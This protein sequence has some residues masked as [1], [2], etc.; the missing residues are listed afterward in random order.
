MIGR[1]RPATDGGDRG[2]GRYSRFV[3]MMKVALPALALLLTVVVVVWPRLENTASDLFSV[4]F[5]GL[6]G[7]MVES[8]R[9]VNARY[10]GTDSDN[11]PFM[12]TADLAEE[13][14]AGSRVVRL[15]HPKADLTL[16]DGA[17]V[18]MGADTGLYYQERG[19]LELQ[20][21]VDLFHDLG[22]EMHT[23][24]VI[25]NMRQGTAVGK[26]PV[27]AQGPTG[28]LTAEGFTYDRAA[29]RVEF[30]G[31]A[32][33]LMRPEAMTQEETKR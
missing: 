8:Q 11:R 23:P 7:G 22:Y 10:H 28:S 27:T 5:S 16:R 20:G 18:M 3:N 9:L 24:S 33:L 4:S 32:R 15:T 25:L 14:A 21:G 1:A 26:E 31:R 29:G 12:V 19:E 13:T 30:T 2:V 6:S 17:W